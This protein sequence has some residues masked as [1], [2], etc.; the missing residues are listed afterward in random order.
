M[1]TPHY[2]AAKLN[3]FWSFMHES[4]KR[5]LFTLKERKSS[6]GFSKKNDSDS[7]R[8]QRS[9]PVTPAFGCLWKSICR[10]FLMCSIALRYERHRS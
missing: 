2:C 10:F 6:L 1:K 7:P 4:Q 3:A 5:E 8:Q 9:E